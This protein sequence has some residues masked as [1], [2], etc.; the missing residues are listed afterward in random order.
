MLDQGLPV[1]MYDDAIAC[2][3]LS[4]ALS[5]CYVFHAYGLADPPQKVASK[6][7]TKTADSAVIDPYGSNF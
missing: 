7:L 3:V 2:D 4:H 6:T 5:V 1:A